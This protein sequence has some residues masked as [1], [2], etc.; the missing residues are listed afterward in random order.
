MKEKVSCRIIFEI[1]LGSTTVEKTIEKLKDI[2]SIHGLP[3]QIVVDNG[4][5]FIAKEF[6][7]YCRRR[8]IELVFIPPY[9]H[10]SNGEAGRFVKTFKKG[11]YKGRKA[12]KTNDVG[13]DE[14]PSYLVWTPQ[15]RQ[16][17]EQYYKKAKERKFEE[18][19]QVLAHA[20]QVEEKGN[21]LEEEKPHRERKK[22]KLAVAMELRPEAGEESARKDSPRKKYYD[23]DVNCMD[24]RQS[25]MRP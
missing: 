12:G 21:L 8:S 3:E 20:D 23:V 19:Q 1:S 9:H 18:G 25:D 5:Q 17:K 22:D 13:F 14:G 10:N 4:P 24:V 6:K 16:M 11:Y 7:E 2:F 15:M